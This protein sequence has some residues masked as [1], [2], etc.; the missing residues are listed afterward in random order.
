MLLFYLPFFFLL[1]IRRPPRSTLFPYTTLFR[2]GPGAAPNGLP[3]LLEARLRV[4]R[5]RAQRRGLPEHRPPAAAERSLDGWLRASAAR[6]AWPGL[7]RAHL[8]RGAPLRRASR[9]RAR[10]RRAD[11]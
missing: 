11:R 9:D 3:A 4:D 5:D 6:E 8:G 7:A 10:R 2:S 1:P